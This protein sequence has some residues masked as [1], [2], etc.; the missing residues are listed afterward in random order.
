MANVEFAS[1]TGP[2]IERP[3]GTLSLVD[4]VISMIMT[5]TQLQTF[6]GFV[7]TDLTQATQ[8]FFFT[9]PRLQAQ[10]KA[11][12]KGRPPYKITPAGFA[13]IGVRAWQVDFSLTV[14][15]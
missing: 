13:A 1:D 15:G 6:E 10:V 2:P 3:K 7:Y 12:F 4:T 11:R 8:S 9:H 5:D 14:I